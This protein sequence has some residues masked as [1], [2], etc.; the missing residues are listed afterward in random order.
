M[1]PKSI[2]LLFFMMTFLLFGCSSSP[3]DSF[4]WERS[5][6]YVVGMK[7]NDFET[8]GIL[9]V[10]DETVSFLHG[11]SQSPLYGLTERFGENQYES[12]FYGIEWK[13]PEVKMQGDIIRKAVL[14]AEEE[15]NWEEKNDTLNGFGGKRK[16][17]NQG[18]DWIEIFLEEESQNILH[19]SAEIE[20]DRIEISFKKDE[21]ISFPS[22]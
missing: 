5:K 15:G 20:D 8:K 21:T 16:V 18:D 7:I 22:A 13:S 19:L 6:E 14:L 3:N 4:H 12:L 10:E 17:A 1:K 9:I 2:L 11:D